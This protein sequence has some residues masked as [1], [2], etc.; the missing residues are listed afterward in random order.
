M[1][2]KNVSYTAEQ[3]LRTLIVLATGILVLFL[4][5][6]K[7]WLSWIALGVLVIAAFS[8][9]LSAKVAW[10]WLKFAEVLG[11]VNSRVLL[12]LVFFVFLVPLALVRRLF[13]RNALDLT[14][15]ASGTLFHERNHRYTAQDLENPW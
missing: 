10:L 13:V 5:F 15:P 3:N 8:D 12:S 4:V 7:P 1:Q 9:W 2:K 6:H 11:K 14:P